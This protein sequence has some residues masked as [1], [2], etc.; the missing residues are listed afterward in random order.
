MSFPKPITRR[1]YL[2]L[3][4]DDSSD[5][6]GGKNSAPSSKERFCVFAANEGCSFSILRIVVEIQRSQVKRNRENLSR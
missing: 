3:Q 6:K 5:S 4:I 2:H 1:K